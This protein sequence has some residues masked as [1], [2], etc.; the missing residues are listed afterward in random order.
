MGNPL[1]DLVIYVYVP[2]CTERCAFCSRLRV[3]STIALVE[4][5]AN[6]LLREIEFVADEPLAGTVRAV[7]FTGGVPLLLGGHTIARLVQRLKRRFAFADDVEITVETVP[8]KIDEHNFRLFGTLGV[9]RLELLYPT[10]NAGEH[11]ALC[12]PGD[13]E[14]LHEHNSMRRAF[15]LENWSVR[16]PYGMPGQTA[17]HW[18]RT[19]DKAC[20]MRPPHVTLERSSGTEL[21]E[22]DGAFARYRQARALLEDA[23]YRRYAGARFALPGAESKYE[24]LLLAGSDV[25]GLGVGAASFVEGVVFRNRSDVA[26]YVE[27]AGGLGAIADAPVALDVDSLQKKFVRDRLLTGE[28][29]RLRAFEYAFGR[30]AGAHV[31][32][33]LDRLVGE[34]LAERACNEGELRYT[35]SDRGVFEGGAVEA[36]LDNA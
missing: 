4:R 19:L 29:L 32:A 24:Q 1:T 20:A 23:G 14:Q 34:R 3:P 22:R 9:N 16:L 5:Y 8:G 35:L 18:R 30:A 6:A 12:C 27:E 13:Y 11:R 36:M 21:G 26:S 2:L 25:I 33:S 10:G 7:R 15:G 17:E 31:L 28:G